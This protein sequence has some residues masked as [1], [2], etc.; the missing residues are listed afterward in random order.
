MFS[1][2]LREVPLIRMPL[3]RQLMERLRE[4]LL[5]KQAGDRL[6]TEA[7]YAKKFGVSVFTVRQAFGGLEREGLVEKRQGSGT[8]VRKPRPSAKH[9]AVLVD[10][11]GADVSPYFTKL[12]QEIRQALRSLGVASRPYL[13]TLPLGT[14]ATGL[15]CQDLLDDVRLGRISGVISFF[16]KRAPEWTDV[17]TR[18]G[19]PVIDPEYYRID[20]PHPGR[21]QEFLHGAF[22]YFLEHGKKH[23]ALLVWESATDGRHDFSKSFRRLA[24]DYGMRVDEHQMDITASGWECGMGWERFRDIWRTGKSRPDGLIVGD[25]GLFKDCQRAILEL[26]ISVP[27]ELSVAVQTSDAV[28][29]MPEFPV[30]VS[31]LRV[32]E[33]AAIYAEEMKDL[34]EGKTPPVVESWPHTAG[35]LLPATSAPEE[36][37]EGSRELEK[38][39]TE[40]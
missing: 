5:D 1:K 14:E 36:D 11:A 22:R 2:N 30:Y 38:S 9:V 28:E 25:D 40:P 35:T 26:G 7:A 32:K 31:Q 21:D 13:G 33:Q 8:F 37:S 17:L 34:I 6:P 27:E 16:T 12:T 23:I 15:T 4:I 3:Y 18:A 19:I 29:L 39:L 20:H 10:V 24:A